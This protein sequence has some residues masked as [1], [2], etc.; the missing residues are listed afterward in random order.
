MLASRYAG[1]ERAR[2]EVVIHTSNS[3]MRAVKNIPPC[4]LQYDC[5]S[6]IPAREYSFQKLRVVRF[7]DSARPFIGIRFSWG[8]IG[9]TSRLCGRINSSTSSNSALIPCSAAFHASC[10]VS[11]GGSNITNS[12]GSFVRKFGNLSALS[13]GYTAMI[14]RRAVNFDAEVIN[15]KLC[16]LRIFKGIQ[17]I[18][19]SDR[20][21]FRSIGGFLT[22]TPYQ[23]CE[24]S[25]DEENQGSGDFNSEFYC[26]ASFLLFLVGF[27]F[28]GWGW[29]NADHGERSVDGVLAC[30][31]IGGCLMGTSVLVFGL[32][33]CQNA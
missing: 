6:L 30:L 11:N 13:I 26:L 8:N 28:A 9:T 23:N 16:R 1:H 15:D 29:W 33:C 12:I 21:A 5:L 19:G 14:Q 18:G 25:I 27:F 24:K 10:E 2:N 4:I 17:V 3:A 7:S 20:S 31:G 22:R 32:Y